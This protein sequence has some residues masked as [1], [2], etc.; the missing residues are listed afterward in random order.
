MNS[1]RADRKAASSPETCGV[2]M[3]VPLICIG[4]AH[5]GLA[6]GHWW[7]AERMF[8]PGATRSGFHAPVGRGPR[9]EKYDTP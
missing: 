9:D 3:L 4:V 7:R 6:L 2:A 5:G 8:S 1:R